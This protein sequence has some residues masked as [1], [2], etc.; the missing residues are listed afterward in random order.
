[1]HLDEVH[2]APFEIPD[3]RASPAFVALRRNAQSAGALCSIGPAATIS[4]PLSSPRRSRSRSPKDEGEIGAHV[5]RADHAAGQV[6]VHR[7]GPDA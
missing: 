6:K 2:A 3:R 1:V 5:A 4:G 7:L